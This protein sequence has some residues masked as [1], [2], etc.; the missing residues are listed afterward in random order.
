MLR[1]EVPSV[2]AAAITTTLLGFHLAGAPISWL[3]VFAPVI[4]MAAVIGALF[5][6]LVVRTFTEGGRLTI[7]LGSRKFTLTVNK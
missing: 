4:V 1:L 5:G 3:L 2:I 6:I 7:K